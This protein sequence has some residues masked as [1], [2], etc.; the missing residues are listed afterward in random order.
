M[1]IKRAKYNLTR[2]VRYGGHEYIMQELILW[3]SQDASGA[4]QLRYSAI[5]QNK[6]ANSIMRVPL[7][8]VEELERK[9]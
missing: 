8:A 4:K 6:A 7:E 1:E 2:P 3:M 5:I 9:E